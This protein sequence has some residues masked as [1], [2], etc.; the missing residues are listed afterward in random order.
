MDFGS[1]VEL[2][3]DNAV[4]KIN[5]LFELIS[6]VVE[7]QQLPEGVKHSYEGVVQVI[8]D[9]LLVVVDFE[10]VLILYLLRLVFY[11]LHL[12]VLLLSYV[13]FFL[14]YFSEKIF[15]IIVFYIFEWNFFTFCNLTNSALKWLVSPAKFSDKRSLSFKSLISC[16]S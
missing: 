6:E 16:W 13:D 14:L 9:R 2:V 12:I 11:W 10:V 7:V 15:K 5:R 1:A 4:V 8:D 3:L